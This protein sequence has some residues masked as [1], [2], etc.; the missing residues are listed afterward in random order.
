MSAIELLYRVAIDKSA[1]RLLIIN[2]HAH[3]LLFKLS[4]NATQLDLFQ[5]FKPEY[6]A[7]NRAALHVSAELSDVD[8]LYDLILILPSKNKQQTQ[9]WMARAMQQLDEHGQILMSCGN[10]HGAKAYKSALQSLAGH[11]ISRSKSKCRIFSAKKTP[12]LDYLLQKQWLDSAKPALI[13]SHG[14]MAQPGLFSWGHAD[15]GSQLLIE[16]LPEHFSGRGMDLCCGYGLLAEH[17]LRTSPDIDQIHLVEADRLALECAI[18]N[19]ST[20]QQKVQTAWL[21]ATSDPLPD[22]LDWIVCNPPFHTGQQLDIDLGKVI[23]QRACQSLKRGGVLYVV[24]NRKLAYEGL[25]KSELQQIHT[26][27]EANGFKI[28]KG[29]R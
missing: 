25:M 24:A 1:A 15:V 26:I 21:D 9:G 29:I 18:Q 28:I 8:S 19:T 3:E 13:P 17:I 23:V 7:L 2:A 4:D 22:K 5:H 11:V 6:A 16:H 20:W 27:T 10:K 14:L 12:S